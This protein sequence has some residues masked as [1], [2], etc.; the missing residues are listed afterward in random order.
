MKESDGLYVD[1]GS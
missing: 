1:P